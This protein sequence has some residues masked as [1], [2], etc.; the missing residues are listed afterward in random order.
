MQS[1]AVFWVVES[2]TLGLNTL[3]FR[4]KTG[5]GPVLVMYISTCVPVLLGASPVNLP[6]FILISP[7]AMVT[8]GKNSPGIN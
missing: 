2:Q 3:G 4:V 5:V 1:T 7:A 6:G 8:P